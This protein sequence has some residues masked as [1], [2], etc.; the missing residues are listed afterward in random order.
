MPRTWTEPW[1][2]R[3]SRRM[4][5]SNVDLPEPEAPTRKTNSPF[6][7]SRVQS[8]RAG[9]VWVG[10][11]LVTLSNLITRRRPESGAGRAQVG[12]GRHRVYVRR[13]VAPVRRDAARP[14]WN[15]PAAGGSACP[16]AGAGVADGVVCAADHEDAAEGQQPQ[17]EH[18]RA[19][20]VVAAG[21][22]QLG[23]QDA[24]RRARRR[25]V[26]VGGRRAHRRRRRVRRRGRGRR[27]HRR[28][29]D[30]VVVVVLGDG[31][32]ECEWVCDGDG[33]GVGECECVW[34]G[35]GLGGGRLGRARRR[36]GR[37]RRGR[38]LAGDRS[39]R[40]EGDRDR[41]ALRDAER[42]VHVLVGTRRRPASAA[43]RWW[44]RR[45]PTRCPRQRRCTGAWPGTRRCCGRTAARCRSRR[46]TGPGTSRPPGGCRTCA[47]PTSRR[48]PSFRSARAAGCRSRR[49]RPPTAASRSCRL[50]RRRPGPRPRRSRARSRAPRPH[51]PECAACGS[52]WELHCR[53]T[54]RAQASEGSVSPVAPHGRRHA[55]T[56]RAGSDRSC[57]PWIRASPRRSLPGPPRA[58]PGRPR[59]RRSRPGT[60][61]VPD[62]RGTPSERTTDRRRPV[63]IR[64][65]DRCRLSRVRPVSPCLRQRIP[66][67]MKSSISPSSTAAVLPVSCSVRRSLTI[68]YG[69]RT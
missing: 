11:S 10:Y 3:S 51:H 23:A 28:D 48:T 65:R 38:R 36:R 20:H 68:W 58:H 32:G 49:R 14:G 15:A 8:S 39:L 63:T 26:R 69:C 45:R 5:R 13:E 21:V 6:S 59:R 19:G 17:G 4:S 54:S 37:R 40:P 7:I 31:L 50:P 52:C 25:A 34:L 47:P 60:R 44:C 43:G 67:S 66:A 16:S 24:G 55:K 30:V 18:Q 29:G 35:D 64:L 33:D 56:A 42:P 53:P 1:D 22:R 12:H 46:A 61:A 57:R 2:G 41:A 62:R 27:A 9:R